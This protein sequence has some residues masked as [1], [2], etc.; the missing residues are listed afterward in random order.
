M[1]YTDTRIKRKI[2]AEEHY[3]EMEDCY[4]EETMNSVKNTRIY[5]DNSS[6]LDSV[7]RSKN[8]ILLECMDT[9]SAIFKYDN[10]AVLN[11]ADYRY[12][13]GQFL[14]GSFAQEEALCHSSNLFN[15]LVRFSDQYYS[16]NREDMNYYLYTNKALFSKDIVFF[17]NGEQRKCDVLTCA[18][19]NKG[20]A[21]KWEGVTDYINAEVLESRI[22]FILK[23]LET[24]ESRN[25]LLGA[26]GCGVFKQ[27]SHQVAVIFE[28]LLSTEFKDKFDTIIFAIP[29][30]ANFDKFNKV[31]N[32]EE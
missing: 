25:I 21:K 3:K 32:M 27:N 19:P 11:F 4:K 18:A 2:L 12:A 9:V 10:L 30:G 29:A 17:K 23:I 24:E 8:N 6:F 20:L 26:F 31:F 28:K 15:V 16:K 7:Y 13:G 14:T 1:Y 22:R 5:S